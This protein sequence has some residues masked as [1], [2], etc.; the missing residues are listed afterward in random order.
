MED[1]TLNFDKAPIIIHTKSAGSNLQRS[2]GPSLQV[3]C[4]AFQ[5]TL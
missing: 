2:Y 3:W 1:Q 4:V 5:N